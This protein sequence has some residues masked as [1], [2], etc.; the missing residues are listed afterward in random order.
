MNLVLE[1]TPMKTA[2]WVAALALVLCGNS[3]AE[4]QKDG[5]HRDCSHSHWYL[6]LA[7]SW[8]AG[9]AVGQS[10]FKDWSFG[11]ET[12]DPS[13]T[14]HETDDSDTGFRVFGG[15]DLG[16]YFAVELGYANFGEAT[17]RSQNDGSGSQ[18]AAGPFIEAIGLEALDVDLLGRLPL[19]ESVALFGKVGAFQW[20]LTNEGSATLQCCG[21]IAFKESDDGTNASY[22]A[23]VRYDGFRPL[24]IV[25]E[26]TNATFGDSLVG[27]HRKA[28]SIALS[29]AYLF[30]S[31]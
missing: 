19:T 27:G 16:R 26:Y 6:D 31:Q 30:K 14:S 9:A 1:R 18:F 4:E 28:E 7:P 21:P 29:L 2:H 22:G 20:K 12:S 3:W 25:A 24:R 13:F 15:V 10:S 8:Y 11:G 17:F 5:E 23:G